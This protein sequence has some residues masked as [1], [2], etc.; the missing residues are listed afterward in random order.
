MK[1]QHLDDHIVFSIVEIAYANIVDVINAHRARPVFVL[2]MVGAD[3]VH[4]PGVIKVLE[5]NSFVRPMVVESVVV[6]RDVTNPRSVAHRFA[7]LMVAVDAAM[8]KA[9]TSRPNRPH[10]FVS[11]T[12]VGKNVH[13]KAVKRWLVAAHPTVPLMVVGCD[14]F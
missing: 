6:R 7:R 12:A 2:R 14:V 5:I 9:V 11:N 13:T 3:V 10:D 8:S 4:F 1:P